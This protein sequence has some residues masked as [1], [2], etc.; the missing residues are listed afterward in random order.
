MILDPA[1]QHTNVIRIEAQGFSNICIKQYFVQKLLLSDPSYR[2]FYM[3][4]VCNK[5]EVGE[6]SNSLHLTRDGIFH[7]IEGRCENQQITF[8]LLYCLLLTKTNYRKWWN[9]AEARK[10]NK[11]VKD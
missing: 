7:R 5:G 10:R 4:L 9:A 2:E 6:N 8:G 11:I 3:S 1:D